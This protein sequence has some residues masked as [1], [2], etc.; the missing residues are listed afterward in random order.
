MQARARAAHLPR[1][2]RERDQ[3]ARI[4]RSVNVLADAHAPENHT[5]FGA[6]KGTRNVAQNFWLNTAN[7]A[8][9]L[10]CEVFQV[11]FFSFPVFGV[12]FNIL[13]IIKLLFDDR[14]HNRVQHR[15]VSTRPELQH[16]AG[17][18]LQCLAARI[19]HN[20]LATTLGELFEI[21][22]SNRMVLNWVSADHNCYIRVLN[23]VESGCHSR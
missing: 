23:L 21:R 17:E 5:C 8:H 11:G 4:I 13:L 9:L 10:G 7:F 15:H 16:M 12:G 18:T 14:M 20:Q 6:S 22:R 1:H 2:Q 3:T 19:H